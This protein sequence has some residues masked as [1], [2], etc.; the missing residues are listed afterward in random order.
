LNQPT[1]AYSSCLE[2]VSIYEEK[3]GLDFD[4]VGEAYILM[5]ESKLILG[6]KQESERLCDR[7]IPLIENSLH[8]GHPLIGEA[9]LIQAKAKDSS[10]REEAIQTI[11]KALEIRRKAF[12]EDHKEVQETLELL[13]RLRNND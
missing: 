13:K 10:R 3:I 2:G 4:M 8:E 7:A 5:A 12:R 9:L 6:E 1:D 11:E